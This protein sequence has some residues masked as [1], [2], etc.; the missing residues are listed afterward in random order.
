[1]IE[2]ITSKKVVNVLLL[3][4]IILIP[5]MNMPY[6]N[7]ILKEL[8]YNAASYPILIMMFLIFLKIVSKK[9][10]LPQSNFSF[11]CFI[12]LIAWSII[13][14]IFNF[15]TIINT[16][17][18]N[19]IGI[20]KFVF[21]FPL[22]IFVF[23]LTYTIYYILY[24]YEFDKEKIRKFII[25][26]M[27]ITGAYAF[28]EV[29]FIMGITNVGSI[30]INVSH[31][32][33]LYSRDRIY[34]RGVRSVAGEASHFAMYL[35]YALPWLI[36]YF[37]TQKKSK[38]LVSLIP[39]S[40]FIVL[41]FLSKSRAGYFILMFELFLYLLSII[42]VKNREFTIKVCLLFVVAIG[43]G[44]FTNKIF[45]N[46]QVYENTSQSLK[47][48]D[49]VESATSDENLSN[50]ARLGMSEGA[51]YMALDHPI[52]GVGIGQYG[53][54]AKKYIPQSAFKSLEVKSWLDETR[55]DL[56]PTVFAIH[57]RILAELGFVGFFIW[58]TMWCS[59]LYQLM[60]RTYKNKDIWSL[61]LMV[62]IAGTLFSGFTLD[63][64]IFYP[65][66]ILFGLALFYLKNNRV[67]RAKHV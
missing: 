54:H 37:F 11:K 59:L 26:S 67:E 42:I 19:R 64:Y 52:F 44:L 21:Q 34:L 51:I 28:I 6:L 36:S 35:A 15:K 55:T 24:K 10:F 25:Y 3:L 17:F 8:S 41:I 7:S 45:Y 13:S 33:Q 9:D 40:Y 47:V 48:K 27:V 20:E 53:F 50:V 57:P 22:L 60:M 61:T 46:E 32:I 39:I 12:A 29:L 56:W 5:F 62:S 4:S 38:F 18:K 65:Y 14:F 16:S 31:Y 23:I 30:L 66:W 58:I 43:V 2:K 1:M 63:T 49:V